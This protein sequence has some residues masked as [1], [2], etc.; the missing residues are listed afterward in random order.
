LIGAPFT[1]T[2]APLMVTVPPLTMSI[3]P[4]VILIDDPPFDSLIAPS[5]T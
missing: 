5:P 4:E 3:A 2:T 1:S